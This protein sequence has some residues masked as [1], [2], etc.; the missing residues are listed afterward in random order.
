[1]KLK[2]K[3]PKITQCR[4]PKSEGMNV[5]RVDFVRVEDIKRATQIINEKGNVKT[6]NIARSKGVNNERIYAHVD[7]IKR[8]EYK[9]FS[10]IPPVVTETEDGYQL[11]SGEHRFNAHKIA[12]EEYM[13]VCVVEFVDYD[14]KEASYWKYIWQ[15]NENMKDL[16]EVE[17]NPRTDDDVVSIVCNMIKNGQVDIEDEDDLDRALVHQHITKGTPKFTNVKNKI[18]G[19]INGYEGVP[20]VFTADEA[21]ED[22][23]EKGLLTDNTVVQ[24]MKAK[25]GKD[26]DYDQRF[27]KNIL[28]A[29]DAGFEKVIAYMHFTGLSVSD[30]RKNREFKKNHLIDEHYKNAKKYVELYESGRLTEDLEFRFIGQIHGEDDYVC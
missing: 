8:G 28:K 29:F 24:M 5:L 21:K 2:P 19:E 12:G 7:V 9:P 10:Y 6:K 20:K 4:L 26:T 15:S 25:T 3:T 27:L 14:G 17:K 1:M 23:D 16:T 22:L 18:L 13:F 30:I 11:V